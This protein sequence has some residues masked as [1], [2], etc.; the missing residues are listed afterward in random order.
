MP[1]RTIVKC[2][3]KNYLQLVTFSN[4]VYVVKLINGDIMPENQ[5][6]F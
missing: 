4:E 1:E 3:L 5:K 2:E 6:S